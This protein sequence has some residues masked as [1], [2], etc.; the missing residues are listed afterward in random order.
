ML[1]VVFFAVL[2]YIYNLLVVCD[3]HVRQLFL[4][5]DKRNYII[6]LA[7]I[8]HL[9]FIYHQIFQL[10]DP[11][12][13][14]FNIF[15]VIMLNVS[16]LVNIYI[17]SFKLFFIS[18]SAYLCSIL[19]I[20]FSFF[21]PISYILNSEMQPLVLFHIL[22]AL[23]SYS[24]LF[25]ASLFSIS[26]YMIN[27]QLKNKRIDVADRSVS[28][29]AIEKLCL[30][31]LYIGWFILLCA[32]LSGYFFVEAWS[33][34]DL[35]KELLSGIA[36]LCYGLLLYYYNRKGLSFKYV[37]LCNLLGLFLLTAAYFGVRI[38]TLI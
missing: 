36:W 34:I 17:N 32:I 7:P 22:F 15:S 11:D 33:T 30:K 10:P 29:L 27:R 38:I 1:M 13:N 9:W 3:S 4:Y 12:F 16:F 28:I 18:F 24:I 14:L 35:F 23:L 8:L 31:F 19:S 26:L 2:F 37:L 5:S 20:L 25:L 21:S 6:F